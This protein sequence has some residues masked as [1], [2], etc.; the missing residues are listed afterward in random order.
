MV[1]MTTSNFPTDK[2]IAFV[3]ILLEDRAGVEAAEQVNIW[4]LD[5]TLTK[6][7]VSAAIDRLTAIPKPAKPKA[8]VVTLDEGMYQKD[9][10]IFRVVRSKTTGRLYAKRLMRE[11]AGEGKKLDFEFDRAYITALT[12]ADRMTLDEAKAAGVLMG[13]CCVCGATLTNET[14]VREGI[15]P[16]CGGRV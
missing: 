10:E 14:S 12:P 4:R 3:R 9:G 7:K 13:A 2:Q 11:N 16:V 6:N 1:H 15:G 8:P 5:G